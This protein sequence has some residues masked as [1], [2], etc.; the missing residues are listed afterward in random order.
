MQAPLIAAYMAA[1]RQQQG[2]LWLY[3]E[4]L[5]RWQAG[6]L[7]AAQRGEIV[8]LTERLAS[9]RAD[10]I[11]ILD[12]ARWLKPH[13]IDA[14]LSRSDLEL[15]LDALLGNLTPEGRRKQP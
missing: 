1:Y 10:I 14:V 11:A 6:K 8:G 4:Q 5:R 15:G 2:D 12:L 7:T 3:E 13:T 9:L